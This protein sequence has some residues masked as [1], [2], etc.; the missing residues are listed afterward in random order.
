LKFCAPPETPA[1]LFVSQS[2]RLMSATVS[3]PS[4]RLSLLPRERL[5]TLLEASQAFNSTLDLDPLLERLLQQTLAITDSEAGALWVVEGDT[6]RCAH[7]AG[8]AAAELSGR[9]LPAGHGVL[10]EA[11]RT[12][13][14]VVLPDA[15]DDPRYAA[16]RDG[17]PGFRTRSVV[18]IPLVAGDTALGALELVNDVGGKELF[19]DVDLVFLEALADDAAAALRNARLFD[20]ERRARDLKALLEVSHEITSSFDLDRVLLGVVNLADRAVRFDRCAIAVWE[21][22]ALRVRAISGVEKLDPKSQA[23]KQIE[24]LLTWTAEQPGTLH[25][26][27][28]RAPEKTAATLRALFGPY[29]EAA[30]VQSLLVVPVRDA[31]GEL[32]RLLFEFRAHAPEEWKREAAELLA[33]EAALA[34]RNAQLYA[35]VPFISLLEPLAQKRRR[36]L[37]LPRQRLLRYTAVGLL[38]VGAAAFIRVPIRV[39]AH[40]AVVHAAAQRPARAGAAG[41]I[42]EILVREGERVAAAQPVARLRNEDLLVRLATTEGELRAAAQR[43]LAAEARGDAADAV[44]ARERAARLR[45]ALGLLQEEAAALVVVS[46]V[47][48]IVLTPR[49]EERVGSWR[50]AGEPVVWIGDADWAEVRLRV[51]QQDIGRVRE[52]DRVRVRVAARPEVRYEGTVQAIAPLA[53]QAGSTTLYTVRTLLDNRDGVLRAGMS[54]R[55]RVLTEPQPLAWTLVR[56]PWRW[57]RLHLWY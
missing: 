53:E 51:P 48:G 13:R 5:Q 26:A 8:P 52:G 43:Q 6:I 3:P 28:V 37:A 23:V 39:T 21:R 14:P 47:T 54:A 19:D 7:A 38:L 25:V 15:L 49:L 22:D 57:L 12:G 2:G 44:A 11:L 41:I 36:L 31:D 4:A 45:N 50:A 30:G 20:A 24:A 40:D 16:Y 27:D 17:A 46:P 33:N 35:N 18:T 55:A 56:R 29:L 32:G 9:A 34:I 1:A 10:A 42:T